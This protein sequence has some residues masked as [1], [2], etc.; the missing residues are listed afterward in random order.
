MQ[1]WAIVSLSGLGIVLCLLA[2]REWAHAGDR[3]E[4]RSRADG[5]EQALSERNLEA[6]RKEARIVS[7]EVEL[8]EARLRETTLNDRIKNLEAQRSH[9]QATNEE[10]A[11]RTR[12][13]DSK[14]RDAQAQL[15]S[16][17]RQ[18]LNL[19][20]QPRELQAKLDLAGARLEELEEALDAQA[21]LMAVYPATVSVEGLSKDGTAFALAGLFPDTAPLPRPVYVCQND[22]IRLEGWINRLENGLAIGHVERWR[23][24]ASTLVKGQKVFILPRQR[25]EAD[26]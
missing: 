19:S 24:P 8:E 17:R 15:E 20:A 10:Q 21:G 14:A 4:W 26:N 6:S 18:V 11:E 12:L 23:V 2:W 1:R 13:A 9:L 5:Y 22:S 16:A 3:Q 25:Y 7:C